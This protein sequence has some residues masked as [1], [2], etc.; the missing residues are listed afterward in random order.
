MSAVGRTS[1]AWPPCDARHR[2]LPSRSPARHAT[3][4][5]APSARDDV[6]EVVAELL[7]DRRGRAPTRRSARSRS[8]RRGRRPTCSSRARRP[9]RP[10]AAPS[11]PAAAPR[12]GSR[13]LLLEELP[14]RHRDD[15]HRGAVLG[16]LAAGLERQPDL[17]AGGDEDQVGRRG[18][19]PERVR[20]ALDARR[21]ARARSG[22]A[23]APSAARATARRGRLCARARPSTP[24]P[25]RSRRPAA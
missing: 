21:R 16:E 22:R 9:A 4:P 17:G 19:L 5:S 8:S 11:R 7:E 23:S 10:R 20:A 13:R 2:A 6:V 3:T 1:T 25:S 14:A 24:T 12:R 18:G 15:A